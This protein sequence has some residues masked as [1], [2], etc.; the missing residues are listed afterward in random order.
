MKK[1]AF[2]VNA[3]RGGVV[4]ESALIEALNSGHIAGAALDVFDNE[5]TPSEAI[6]S[7]PKI[8]L[9]PHVGAATLEAQDRI[10]EELADL[11]M[12]EMTPA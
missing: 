3:A 7:H 11:I 10:G 8:A 5:P 4:E 9:T 12:A 6:L 2:I 1:G